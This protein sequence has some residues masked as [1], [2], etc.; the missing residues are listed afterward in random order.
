MVSNLPWL[1]TK[2]YPAETFENGISCVEQVR[3]AMQADADGVLQ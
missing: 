2:V 3:R 1:Q